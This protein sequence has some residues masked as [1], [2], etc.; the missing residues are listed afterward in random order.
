M[1]LTLDT[2]HALYS[3]LLSLICVD[4]DS[5]VK[6]LMA[7]QTCTKHA[8]CTIGSGTYGRH[9]RTVLNGNLAEGVAL[10]PGLLT[11]P[12]TG[13]AAGTTFVAINAGNSRASRGGV[14]DTSM[15]S[16]TGPGVY[17][18][19]AVGIA[20][21]SNYPTNLGTTDIIGT[22]AHSFGC[23]LSASASKTF[24]NGTVEASAGSIGNA[25]DGYRGQYIGGSPS[26]GVGGFAADYVWVAQF[27]RVLTDAEI[28]SLH[29]SLGASNAFGLVTSGDTTAPTLTSPAGTQTGS[30]TASGT[31]S[32]DEG[33]GTLYYL[34]SVNATETAAT[35]KAAA[36]Q[37]VSG[38]GSQSV[39][40]TGLTASTTYYAHY[41]HRDAAGNDST[42]SNSASF[43]TAAAASTYAPRLFTPRSGMGSNFFGA[44]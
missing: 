15:N 36:S 27:N 30:T 44:R 12:L 2:G 34:A 18:G 43:T 29:S 19:D 7:A 16:A 31:V 8:N 6:D 25:S 13:T 11:K 42:V 28:T 41:C 4:D 38:T 14:L 10:S 37:A 17:T 3:A 9:F 23:T 32:T 26:G 21:S 40:F 22:G 24:V 35:V 33:N 5:T 39:S 1:A 20:A